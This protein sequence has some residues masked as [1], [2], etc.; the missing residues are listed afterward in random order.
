MST[1]REFLV[2]T[3]NI[4]SV[5]KNFDTFLA[6]LQTF[7]YQPDFICLTEVWINNEETPVYGLQDYSMFAVCN[8][9]YRSGGIMVYVHSRFSSS[10]I[11]VSFVTADSICINVNLY[12]NSLTFLCIYRLHRFAVSHFLNELSHC[13]DRLNHRN[14]WVVGDLNIDILN[15]SQSVQYDLL[16]SEHE[17]E[18]LVR[19]P[20]RITATSATCIDHVY[21][22]YSNNNICSIIPKVIHAGITDHSLISFRIQ[23][24]HKP[25]GS[26]GGKPGSFITRKVDYMGLNLSLRNEMWVDVYSESNIDIAYSIFVSRLVELIDSHTVIRKYQ[27]RRNCPIKPWITRKLCNKIHKKNQ[28]VRS[29]RKNPENLRLVEYSKSYSKKVAREISLA[30]EFYYKNRLNSAKNNPKKCWSIINEMVSRKDSVKGIDCITSRL[31]VDLNEGSDIANELNRFFT[32]VAQDSIS[33]DGKDA[34]YNHKR[35]DRSFFFHPASSLE[36]FRVIKGLKNNCTPGID[37]ISN[38]TLKSIA[39]N[40]VD[41][42]AYLINTSFEMGVFPNLL[43]HAV[44][45]PL[46]KKGDRKTLTNY[47]PISILPAISKIYEKV[48]RDRVY[49]FLSENNYFSDVQ[50]GFRPGSGCEDALSRFIGD[51]NS[52]LNN[53]SAANMALF[54]DLTKAFDSVR[55][56]VLLD[57][58]DCAG[59]RGLPLD[60]LASYLDSRPQRVKL[61]PYIFS[62]SAISSVG[63]PQ[64]SVLGPLLF[65]IYINDLLELP[66]GGRPVAYADDIA[67]IYS[68]TSSNEQVVESMEGDLLLIRK[69][70]QLH[71]MQIS[72]KTESMGFGASAQYLRDRFLLC[73]SP[74]CDGSCDPQCMKIASVSKF[75]YLGVTLDEGLTW[76]EH[77]SIVST[78]LK[79]LAHQ[80][81]KLRESCSVGLLRAFYFALGESR[82]RY[83]LLCWGGACM[84]HLKQVISGQ[85]RIVRTMTFKSRSDSSHPIFR[86]LRI[87]PFQTLYVYKVTD[88]FF[89]C[90]GYHMHFFRENRVGSRERFLVPFPRSQ[91]FKRSLNYLLPLILNNAVRTIYPF[92]GGRVRSW[93]LA[94]DLGEIEKIMTSV[95]V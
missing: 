63:V 79:L 27:G 58:L 29:A 44:V 17:L 50:F 23:L 35:V 91:S 28:L 69:W 15:M 47:R 66:L 16:M 25:G 24:N 74:S 11:D 75:K 45:I 26:S 70:L 84:Q 32:S 62:D 77:T 73:H 76:R 65:L 60:W 95:Y 86:S 12:G 59:F 51:L 46:Y 93:L 13:L 14:L 20:T 3:Q 82:M 80:M 52:N 19:E 78:S 49:G 8:N 41:V 30:K 54:I 38:I 61:T 88:T 4:R 87:M 22:R 92:V 9:D 34:E 1:Q 89:K 43:K 40:I 7:S 48:V 10:Q 67:L 6:T 55:H 36:L 85:K 42:L 90:S 68:N 64:G 2:L 83:G 81:Y 53:G 56:G 21:C 94:A 31:G 72:I 18:A 39:F 5:S 57:K 37:G 71:G 33:W